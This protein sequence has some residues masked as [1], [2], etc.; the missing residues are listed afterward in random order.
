M[1]AERTGSAPESFPDE[2]AALAEPLVSKF[3]DLTPKAVHGWLEIRIA[4]EKLLDVARFLREEPSLQFDYLS[5]ISAVDYQ[6][7]GF[8]V[9]YHLLN[10]RK[11]THR[12]VLKV[13][14][15]REDPLVPTVTE[16]WPT[17]NWHEREAWDLMGIRFTGHPD[18]R[19]ILMR[20][21]W[22]GHPLRKDYVD[23]RPPR[24][25]MTREKYLQETGRANS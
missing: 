20:E 21:D 13:R 5:S 9:V 10:L 1:P 2:L 22:E 23:N 24:D 11:P 8:E 17:A 16:I 4:R 18:L 7:D 25:R 6:S 19:R 14:V 3:P 12:L 15:P